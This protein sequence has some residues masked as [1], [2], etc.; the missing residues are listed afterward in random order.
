MYMPTIFGSDFFDDFMNFPFED[1][2]FSRNP[3]NG[4]KHQAAVMKT[5][6]RETDGAYTMEVD[7]PG[8][9]KDEISMKLDKGYLTISASKNTENEEKDEKGKY[10]RRERY[11]GNMSRSFFVGE[12]LTQEDVKAKF[13]NGIL[14]VTIPKVD[15]EKKVPENK[16]IAIEG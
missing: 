2:F 6:I 4:A 15:P 10:V 3:K 8:F 14:N 16:Y 1:R 7:L 12:Q 13:E 5:D 9:T 11:L